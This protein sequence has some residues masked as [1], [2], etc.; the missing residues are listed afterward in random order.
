MIESSYY[1]ADS[2]KDRKRPYYVE[3]N[4]SGKENTYTLF[5][6]QW[7]FS[8]AEMKKMESDESFF[9]KG[10]VHPWNIF[11]DGFGPD[12]CVPDRAWVCWM[13]DALNDKFE[14][15]VMESGDFS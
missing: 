11:S 13:V 4:R 7:L 6:R 8:E 9:S 14:K 5:R 3:F 12:G 1:P 2:D 15:E 10:E